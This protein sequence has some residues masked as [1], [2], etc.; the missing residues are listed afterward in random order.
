M[1]GSCPQ[2]SPNSTIFPP[3]KVVQLTDQPCSATISSC[4]GF[5]VS[6]NFGRTID[7]SRRE[8]DGV[9]IAKHF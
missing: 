4:R 5:C 8:R 1:V 9:V 3:T 6:T 7:G 2:L